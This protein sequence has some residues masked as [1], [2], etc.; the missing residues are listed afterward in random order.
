MN[1]YSVLKGAPKVPSSLAPDEDSGSTGT[2]LPSQCYKCKHL[3]RDTLVT[4]AA[5]PDGIPLVILTGEYDHT[6]WF[7]FDGVSDGGVTFSEMTIDN[8]QESGTI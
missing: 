7:D 1:F 5:F 3:N 4:C 2:L 8:P 6:F